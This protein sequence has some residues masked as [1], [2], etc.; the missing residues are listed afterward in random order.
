MRRWCCLIRGLGGVF[1]S[2][3]PLDIT[4]SVAMYAAGDAMLTQAIVQENT[5][6]KKHTKNTTPGFHCQSRAAMSGT[7]KELVDF[8]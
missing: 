3:G 7:S 2:E 6:Q 1:G 5:L 4:G 8:F